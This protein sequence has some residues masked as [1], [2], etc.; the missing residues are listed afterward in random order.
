MSKDGNQVSLV[1]FA[2]Q[3]LPSLQQPSGLYCFDR[4]FDSP[5]IRGES[6]RYSLMVLL[7]LSRAQSSGHP[8][9]APEIERP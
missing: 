5:E 3:V 6:V 8:D 9:L 1:D 2:F 7:G 4:T